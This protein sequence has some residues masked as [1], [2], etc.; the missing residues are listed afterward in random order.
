MNG[1]KP[2]PG[3][4]GARPCMEFKTAR[5]AARPRTSTS[6]GANRGICTGRRGAGGQLVSVGA[7]QNGVAVSRER[8]L[9]RTLWARPG[10]EGRGCPRPYSNVRKVRGEVAT[11]ATVPVGTLSYTHGSSSGATSRRH[12]DVVRGLIRARR[13]SRNHS[14]G[15]DRETRS[16]DADASGCSAASW[17]LPQHKLVR[18]RCPPRLARFSLTRIV[19]RHVRRDVRARR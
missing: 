11:V 5:A 1:G 14:R 6:G 7:A 2:S 18:Q 8:Q 17:D 16:H 15:G 13:D 4:P 9:H 19:H 10:P 3:R 12:V